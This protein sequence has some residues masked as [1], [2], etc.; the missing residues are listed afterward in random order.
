MYKASFDDILQKRLGTWSIAFDEG[1][2]LALLV[3]EG[4]EYFKKSHLIDIRDI[5]QLEPSMR[6][7]KKIEGR[8][9]LFLTFVTGIQSSQWGNQDPLNV[10]ADRLGQ[11]IIVLDYADRL[12]ANLLEWISENVPDRVTALILVVRD[13]KAFE[14][15]A[16]ELNISEFNIEY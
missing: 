8:V 13:K 9:E 4:R 15:N 10:L 3:K 14:K 11:T 6:E 5:R 1:Y 2:R 16:K 12:P 7:I